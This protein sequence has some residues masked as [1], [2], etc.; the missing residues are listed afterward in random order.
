[1]ERETLWNV[2]WL[3]ELCKHINMQVETPVDHQLSTFFHTIHLTLLADFDIGLRCARRGG[4]GL[5]WKMMM[6]MEHDRSVSDN[7]PR[8]TD[9]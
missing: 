6:M 7:E 8:L 4:W 2:C 9:A 1:M 3:L 5:A